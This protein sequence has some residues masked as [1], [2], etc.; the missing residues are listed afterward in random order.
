M[1]AK[2]NPNCGREAFDG[3]RALGA[4]YGRIL[5][6]LRLKPNAKRS[7]EQA[8]QVFNNVEETLNARG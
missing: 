2:R 5:V 7:P 4:E 3:F 8:V 6:E 1:C